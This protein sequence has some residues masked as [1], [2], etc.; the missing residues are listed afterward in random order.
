M[1]FGVIVGLSVVN[2][3][4]TPCISRLDMADYGTG[5]EIRIEK[6]KLSEIVE[7]IDDFWKCELVE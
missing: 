2:I 5:H 1:I 6:L 7:K 4:M 3:F